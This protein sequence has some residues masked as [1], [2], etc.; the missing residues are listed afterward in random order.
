MAYLSEENA[1][2]YRALLSNGRF[3]ADTDPR[4]PVAPSTSPGGSYGNPPVS[5]VGPLPPAGPA[6]GPRI[7]T[8][9]INQPT[10]YTPRSLPGRTTVPGK[11]VTESTVM[12]GKDV[13]SPSPKSFSQAVITPTTTTTAQ[14]F[15][16]LVY[17][18]GAGLLLYFLFKK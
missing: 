17:I 12:I 10:G 8:P 18:G 5:V 11:T 2:T 7:V 13:V 9:P 6:S 1:N 16:P 3:G 4:E 14:N 15:M